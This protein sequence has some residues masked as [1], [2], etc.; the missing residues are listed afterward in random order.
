LWTECSASDR[1][2]NTACPVE[3]V[4]MIAVRARMDFI[5]T[6]AAQHSPLS[7]GITNWAELDV[8]S[9]LGFFSRHNA[10]TEQK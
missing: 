4:N 2:G 3:A 5:L 1:K 6:L 10:S 9:T 8:P 7:L